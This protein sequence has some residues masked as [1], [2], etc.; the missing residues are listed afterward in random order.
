ML[1][2]KLAA[3]I[4]A[5]VMIFSAASPAFAEDSIKYVERDGTT[6][7]QVSGLGMGPR[8]ANSHGIFSQRFA[9]QV[10]KMDA[11]RQFAEIIQSVDIEPKVQDNQPL[12]SVDEITLKLDA[13]SLKNVQ[14]PYLVEFEELNDGN[15]VCKITMEMLISAEK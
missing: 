13:L 10:A 9:M 3:M 2:K 5:A 4:L 14:K 15:L 12:E 1:A 6:Y 8:G 7:V 11:L